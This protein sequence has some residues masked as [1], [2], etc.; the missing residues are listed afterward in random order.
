LP[1]QIYDGRRLVPIPAYLEEH[2]RPDLIDL[3]RRMK[4]LSAGPYGNRAGDVLLLSKTGLEH[5]ITERYYFSGP[6]HS[7]HGSPSAQ[8][9]HVPL[10]LARPNYSGA[11]LQ[12]MIDRVAHEP[13]PSQLDVVPIVLSL[14]KSG[15][16]PTT[17][18][19][20]PTQNPV[21][22]ASPVSAAAAPSE[23]PAEKSR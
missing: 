17:P 14:L 18:A 13:M 15:S 19:A 4:W 9:S 10:I 16:T 8:D 6:Y 22:A 21:N 7:W 1:F 20:S 23:M 11:A 5:P 2:P 12:L 3:D